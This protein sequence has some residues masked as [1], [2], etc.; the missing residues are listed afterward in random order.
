MKRP[1]ESKGDLEVAAAATLITAACPELAPVQIELLGQGWDN[2]VFLVNGDWAFRFPRR[3]EALELQAN[4]WRL[5]PWL[6]DQLPLPIP[7]PVRWCEASAPFPWPFYGHR[8]LPGRTA[9]TF[10]LNTQQRKRLV[11]PIARFLRC[12]HRVDVSAALAHGAVADSFGRYDLNKRRRQFSER[13]LVLERDGL[14]AHRSDAE[15]LFDA[16]W[17]AGQSALAERAVVHGDLY[18]RHLLL[19]EDAALSGIIDWGDVH[20]GNPAT[21]LALVWGF[22]PP[23]CHAAFSA[24]YGGIDAGVWQLARWRAL[25]HY[26][27]IA[28]Y[29]D[30]IQ[31]RHLVREGLQA[32]DWLTAH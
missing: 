32:L 16:S 14:F 9:C 3:D 23:D 15:K 18:V 24:V 2:Q 6:V 12:L 5:L 4:E 1:W 17:Q 7:K 20:V 19:D 21:D 10:R 11:N 25:Q 30:A 13:L 22:L 31:D 26:T 27:A 8:L 29:G 28:W